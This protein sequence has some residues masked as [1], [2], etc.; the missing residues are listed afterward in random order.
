MVKASKGLRR[1]TRRKL[2][3]EVR[4]K[5]TV[6]KIIKKF[7][8]GDKVIIKISP[9]SRSGIPPPRYLGL[10]GIV[11]FQRGSSYMVAVRMGKKE[12]SF[13]LGPEHLKPMKKE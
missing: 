8:P 1:G 6:E 10:A 2:K 4:E 9:S 3:R 12:K 11:K 7:K 13:I 5:F